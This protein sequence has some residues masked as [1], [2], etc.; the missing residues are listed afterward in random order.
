MPATVLE[1]K[2]V[3]RLHEALARLRDDIDRVE[4]WTDALA[5]FT[6]P[7]PD[8]DPSKTS[9]RKF[10]LPQA[11]NADAAQSAPNPAKATA[12]KGRVEQA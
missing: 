10:M 2:I 7:V 5:T 12:H 6:Q 9:L 4:L 8:Y 1:D 3:L 11:T